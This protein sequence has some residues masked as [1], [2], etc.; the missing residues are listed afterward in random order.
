MI[1]AAYSREVNVDSTIKAL[2]TLARSS[3]C[4][5]PFLVHAV[6][7]ATEGVFLNE[8]EGY[9]TM[10]RTDF[11]LQVGQDM[12]VDFALDPG[13]VSE[14]IIVSEAAPMIETANNT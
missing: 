10:E 1:P 7:F 3:P 9:K 8:A 13:E 5:V 11:E 2:H 12:R 6:T 4:V 14:K